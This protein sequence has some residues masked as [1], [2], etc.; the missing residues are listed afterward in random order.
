MFLSKISLSNKA[1]LIGMAFVVLI[2]LGLSQ[3]YL[4]KA[5]YDWHWH[6]QLPDGFPEPFVPEDNPM[7]EI[8]FQL[9]RH[10]F[11]DKRLSGNGTMACASCHV[12]SLAFTDKRAKSI[13]STGEKTDRGAMTLVNVAYFPSLTWANPSLTLLERQAMV[14][15]FTD[16]LPVEMGIDQ[17][18]QDDVL[19]RIV[20][21][22]QYRK[23]FNAAFPEVIRVDFSHIIKAI[24]TFE[25]GLISANSKFDKVQRGE[26]IFTP[27]EMVGNNL[28]F[29][30]AQCASCHKGLNFSDQFFAKGKESIE[31][32]FHNTGLY[33]I[34]GK[35]LYPYDNQG[36]ISVIPGD[37]NMGKFRTQTLRN[38]ALTAPYMHD[39]SIDTLEE[40]LDHYARHGRLVSEGINKGD[41]KLSPLKD[42]ILDKID[43][44]DEDKPAL[45]AFLKT[46]TDESLLVNPRFS[47][48]FVSQQKSQ[49]IE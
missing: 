12:Q 46:L 30:R 3:L 5:T 13:G 45:I 7:S 15:L 47:D 8:K 22:T 1:I 26:E 9:G 48:P 16:N 17:S 35:G 33:N 37:D 21:D 10:L 24:A 34:D 32:S 19:A 4:N 31:W 42:P 23:M 39:G 36:L 18:N 27:I 6:W 20:Q 38:I 49:D 11:Y 2:V 29:G 28:F 41:G 43:L 14:P 25:R 40:V 44:K